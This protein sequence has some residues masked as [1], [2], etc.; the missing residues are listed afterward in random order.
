MTAIRVRLVG[1]F[2]VNHI[3]VTSVAQ[4]NGHLREYAWR[5]LTEQ[6]RESSPDRE[7]RLRL[8]YDAC[9]VLLDAGLMLR[10]YQAWQDVQCWSIDATE[11]GG[12]PSTVPL[13]VSA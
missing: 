3:N 12:A 9:D 13:E 10:A 5:I 7:T 8:L 2:G 4:V 6:T 11:I 1:P